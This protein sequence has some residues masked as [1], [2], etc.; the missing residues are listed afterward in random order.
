MAGV[1]YD[2]SVGA[3]HRRS[4]SSDPPVMVDGLATVPT[5][6]D[7]KDCKY[8]VDGEPDGESDGEHGIRVSATAHPRNRDQTKASRSSEGWNPVG[9]RRDPVNMVAMARSASE[10][11][12]PPWRLPRRS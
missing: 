11:R 8:Y 10:I 1:T 6:V 3:E 2:V 7:S 4:V 12:D 9:Q 5:E